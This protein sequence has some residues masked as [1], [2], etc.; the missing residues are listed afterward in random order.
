MLKTSHLLI[1][2]TTFIHHMRLCSA[3]LTHH[4][5]YPVQFCHYISYKGF[6]FK[7]YTIIVVAELKNGDWKFWM[8]FMYLYKMTMWRKW[9][10]SRCID[11]TVGHY[12]HMPT[13]LLN[14]VNNELNIQYIQVTYEIAFYYSWQLN[15]IAIKGDTKNRFNLKKVSVLSKT[16]KRNLLQACV[17]DFFSVTLMQ[18]CFFSQDAVTYYTVHD[19][20]RRVRVLCLSQILIDVIFNKVIFWVLISNTDVLQSFLG[21]F[22]LNENWSVKKNCNLL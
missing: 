2:C 12:I 21:F 1:L 13:S 18:W 9:F 14:L 7:T 3:K 22:S 8:E 11:C 17:Q 10:Y 6:S 15:I 16:I 5:W 19:I 4:I 20:L